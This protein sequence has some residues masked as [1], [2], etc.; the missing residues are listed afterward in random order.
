[1]Q[2]FDPIYGT[3]ISTFT[4]PYEIVMYLESFEQWEGEGD[5]ASKFGLEIKDKLTWTVSKL[6]FLD[7]IGNPNSFARPREG[8]LIYWPTAKR[9]FQIKYVDAFDHLFYQFGALQT[10]KMT[11]ELFEYSD[12]TFDTGIKEID[13]L[14][15]SFSLNLLDWALTDSDGAPLLTNGRIGNNYMVVDSFTVSTV[16]PVADNDQI[17]KETQPFL[18]FSEINPFSEDFHE[19]P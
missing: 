16:D 18:D 8:D 6:V 10:W 3:D 15:K 5:I 1:L 14:Q 7:I 12:E 2:N 11:V 19:A 17:P 9:T 4:D 13:L